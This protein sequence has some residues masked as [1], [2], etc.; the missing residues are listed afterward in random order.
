MNTVLLGDS[1]TPITGM[2]RHYS[3]LIAFK[4]DGAFAI[5]Y[6]TITLPEGQVTAG[7]YVRPINSALGQ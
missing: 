1:S 3:E 6:D 2:Q 4:T 5:N 7:F